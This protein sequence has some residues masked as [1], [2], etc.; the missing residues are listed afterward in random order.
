MAN[1][2]WVPSSIILLVALI[3]SVLVSISLPFLAGLDISRV[4]S[5][6]EV[7]ESLLK[8]FRVS[9]LLDTPKTTEVNVTSSSVFGRPR[10]PY[11]AC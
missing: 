6:Q 3:L 11:L 2:L 7:F 10:T 8:E 1:K 4:S 9:L 5:K